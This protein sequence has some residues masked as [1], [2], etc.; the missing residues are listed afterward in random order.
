MVESRSSSTIRAR[1]RSRSL[2]EIQSSNV[3]GRLKYSRY[4][5]R[6]VD[7]RDLPRLRLASGEATREPDRVRWMLAGI[8]EKAF[9]RLRTRHRRGEDERRRRESEQH[10][11]LAVVDETLPH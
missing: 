8:R 11:V 5:S 2:L 3:A 4:A 10:L 1:D 6:P 9:D 7:W